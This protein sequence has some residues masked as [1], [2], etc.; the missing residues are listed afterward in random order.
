[1]IVSCIAAVADNGVI[2]KDKELPWR[3]SQDLKRFKKLTVGH[4]IIMGR[5]TFESIGRPLPRR[6]SIV[7]TRN[8]DFDAP[9][10]VVVHSVEEAIEHAR[11]T[12]QR[13]EGE[14]EAFVIGG[15][16]IFREALPLC[17]RLYLTRVHTEAPGNILFPELD[18]A[19]WR[20]G[21]KESR[22]ADEKNQHP[23]TFVVYERIART[24]S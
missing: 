8:T 5:K 6:V 19:R 9:G 14:R 10:A 4:V 3:L 21:D 15:E 7:V 22:A 16:A 12:E 20:A 24:L 11:Q 2:G 13:A 23:T 18:W 1:M 17:S